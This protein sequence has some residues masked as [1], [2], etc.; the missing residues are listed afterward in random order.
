[1]PLAYCSLYWEMNCKVTITSCVLHALW[2]P[3]LQNHMLN[4]VLCMQ[5]DRNGL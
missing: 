3:Y 4:S 1:M 2:A 5:A